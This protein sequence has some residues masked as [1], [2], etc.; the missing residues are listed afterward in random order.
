MAKAL[1]GLVQVCVAVEGPAA[2]AV[3]PPLPPGGA[4]PPTGPAP[5]PWVKGGAAD[6]SALPPLTRQMLE[7]VLPPLVSRLQ[8]DDDKDTVAAASEALA[9]VA[10]LVGP[11]AVAARAE[12]L[13]KV[14]KQLLQQAH[15]CQTA[16][17]EAEELG[18]DDEADHDEA[19][20]EAVS[21]LL[22]SLPK[23]LGAAWQPH[24]AA[25]LPHLLPYLGAGHPSSDRSLAVGVIAESMHQLEA[26]A[27]PLIA[28]VVPI[29]L[30]HS[31][32]EDGTCRQNATFCLGVM[33]QHCPAQ[34]LAH[35]QAI[36]TALQPRLAADEEHPVRD[37]AVGALGRLALAHGGALPLE[38]IV[39]AMLAQL[40]LTADCGENAPAL[41]ALMQL[42]HAEP[43][44]AV[45]APHVPALLSALGRG[46]ALS[47]AG[48]GKGEKGEVDLLGAELRAEVSLFLQW[49]ASQVP[50]QQ[51]AAATAPLPESERAMLASSG[52]TC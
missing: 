35:M 17:V 40:P 51:L 20:W 22:T 28:Q 34:T 37:N 31:A 49:L 7:R 44:R 24:F 10:K 30:R 5:L 6:G 46:L 1:R 12:A 33:A 13:A 21:E 8:L 19:L 4:K 11:P 27:A 38:G 45:M 42:T 15:P 50:A 23:V 25:L 47:P 48:E 52:L 41:R 26:E 14:V 2:G 36:L 39:P 3:P 16:G 9:D 18:M 43:T 32:D 29:A